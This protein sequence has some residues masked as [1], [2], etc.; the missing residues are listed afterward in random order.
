MLLVM[1]L[2]LV[3]GVD[4]DDGGSDIAGGYV[5]GDSVVGDDADGAAV[6]CVCDA[7]HID[8][9]IQNPSDLCVLLAHF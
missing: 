3:V 7:M 4:D 6:G 8:S 5:G 2:L 9:I 1:L